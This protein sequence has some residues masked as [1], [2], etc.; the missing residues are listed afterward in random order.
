V[1][2]RP[3][4]APV[5]CGHDRSAALCADTRGPGLGCHGVHGSTASSEWSPGDAGGDR[6]SRAERRLSRAIRITPPEDSDRYA[7]EWRGDLSSAAE[8]G[9]SPL[10]VARGAGR[11]AWRLRVRRWGR[12]LAGTEGW[13]RAAVAWVGVLAILP[14]PLVFGGPLLQIP[15]SM[16]VA[17]HLAPRSST[18]G[19]RGADAWHRGSVAG[20]HGRLLVALGRGLRCG[21]R[22][23][24]SAR[25]HE[26]G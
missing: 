18:G 21:R 11:V 26:V 5:Q 25:H 8:L 16:V 4:P 24:A 17:L 7:S 19:Q 10:E 6:V 15:A 1:V 9:I 3:P 22:K 2:C 12:V 23:P 14:V 20:V 13:A